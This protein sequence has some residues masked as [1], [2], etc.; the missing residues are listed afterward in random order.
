MELPFKFW[1]FDHWMNFGIFILGA[2]TAVGITATTR[3]W[4]VPSLFTPATVIGFAIS[5]MGFLRA[6]VTDKARDPALG[7]RST[8]PNPTER[9]V[10]VGQVDV[11]V[12]PVTPGRPL[13]PDAPKP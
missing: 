5:V 10:K 2:V 9:V 4:D 7:S 8:D 1:T 13:D 3:W 6:S 11:G 12:P